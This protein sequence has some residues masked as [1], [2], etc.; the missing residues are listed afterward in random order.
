MILGTLRV[1]EPR[2]WERVGLKSATPTTARLLL[3]FGHTGFEY[4]PNGGVAV[5][6]AVDA[7]CLGICLLV[8]CWAAYW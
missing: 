2:K 8:V 6:T 5:D 4:R 7:T 1:E 3:L